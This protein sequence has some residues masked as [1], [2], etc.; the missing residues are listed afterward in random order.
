MKGAAILLLLA[1]GILVSTGSALAQ[2]DY[3]LETVLERM[4]AT[5]R[6]F[7]SLE[8]DIERTHVTVFVNARTIDSGKIYFAGKGEDSRIRLTLTQPTV[9]DALVADG[10]A[11][12]YRPRINRLETYDLGER[13][14]I[15]EFMII[16][17]GASNLTLPEDYDVAFVGDETVDGVETSV[18][19]LKPRSE[20]IAGIF[21]AIR[22]WIDQQRWIPVQSRLNQASGDYQIV[23]YSDIKINGRIPGSAFELDVPSDVNR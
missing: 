6:E 1:T 19:E 17:F 2:S 15:A 18:L 16:G 9:Q 11:Q 3:S 22:L 10:K 5:G 13:R 14:D 7:R 23:K 21:P 8:A 12:I 20:R 4:A